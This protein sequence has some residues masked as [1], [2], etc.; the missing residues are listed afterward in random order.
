MATDDRAAEIA[1]LNQQLSD[2]SARLEEYVATLNTRD[3]ELA[4]AREALQEHD[5]Q[6]KLA[7]VREMFAKA[8]KEFSEEAAGPFLELS[9]PALEAMA[10]LIQTPKLPKD[11]TRDLAAGD[12]EADT[13][14]LT[15]IPSPNE[16]YAA[17]RA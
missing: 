10:S 11:L 4:S 12:P 16:I 1:N 8:G 15:N 9:T 14:K 7:A 17:R 3:Q 5:R 6:A 2:M 13:S